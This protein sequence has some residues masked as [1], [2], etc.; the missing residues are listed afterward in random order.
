MTSYLI[1][2]ES[3]NDSPCIGNRPLWKNG[4]Y[5]VQ[6]VFADD[7]RIIRRFYPTVQFFH[8]LDFLE[9]RGTMDA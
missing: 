9:H 8:T 2:Y 7:A 6:T 3:Y 1:I 4:D 5:P